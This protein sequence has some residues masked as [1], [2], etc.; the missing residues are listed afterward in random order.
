MAETAAELRAL[1]EAVVFLNHFRELP[2]PRCYR[3]KFPGKGGVKDSK[4]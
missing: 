2:D 3:G 1:G 4:M